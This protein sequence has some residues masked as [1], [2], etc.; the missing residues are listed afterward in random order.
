MLQFLIELGADPLLM[1]N[2]SRTPLE[3]IGLKV[4]I[5]CTV[6][7]HFM[8]SVE[9]RWLCVRERESVDERNVVRDK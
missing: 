1:N 5:Q 9:E 8:C 6:D 2:S 3:L 7:V 4:C